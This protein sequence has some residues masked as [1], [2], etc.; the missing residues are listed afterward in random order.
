M[1]RRSRRAGCIFAP[2]T[3]IGGAIAGGLAGGALGMFHKEGLGL[4]DEQKDDIKAH[5]DEGKGLLIV[6]VDDDELDDTKA[7]LVELGGATQSSK[8]NAEEI[9]KA[10]ETMAEA[11]VQA[12]V[13]TV[14]DAPA[15]AGAE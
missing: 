6:L 15:D 2:A 13:K 14:A 5:L 8:A 1:G 10:D 9:E 7:K 4:S 12:D 3:L 11:G